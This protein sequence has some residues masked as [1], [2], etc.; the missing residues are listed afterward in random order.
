MPVAEYSLVKRKTSKAKAAFVKCQTKYCRGIV[1]KHCKRVVCPKCSAKQW[2]ERNPI[3]YAFHKLRSRAKERGHSFTLTFEHYHKL[4]LESG[5]LER[6]GKTASSL[7]IDRIDAT[8]GY[9]DGNIQVMTLAE[10]SRKRWVPY[11][12]QLKEAAIA[13]NAAEVSTSEEPCEE[14]GSPSGPASG[15][16]F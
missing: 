8:K 4:V 15:E 7:S 1:W 3:R 2:R 6:K 13:A 10:N 9:E 5:Y 14:P 12:A 16:P 11:F